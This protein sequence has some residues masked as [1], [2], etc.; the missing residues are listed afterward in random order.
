MCS[1]LGCVPG[2]PV[3]GAPRG[4]GPL[5]KAPAELLPVNRPL[6]SRR[7]SHRRSATQAA[8]VMEEGTWL[9]SVGGRICLV[10]SHLYRWSL[11]KAFK[12]KSKCP[13]CYL[14]T[15]IRPVG[16]VGRSRSGGTALCPW[17]RAGGPSPERPAD[18]CSLL[19]SVHT[20]RCYTP[21]LPPGNAG[22]VI[23]SPRVAIWKGRPFCFA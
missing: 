11:P 18:P 9:I 6:I 7:R 20:C 10:C 8:T 12:R 3:K 16:G 2:R 21:G 14:K 15:R 4:L 22:S 23:T 13:K 19:F 5:F 1:S 17:G